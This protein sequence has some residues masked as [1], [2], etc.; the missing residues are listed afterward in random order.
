[1]QWRFGWGQKA[2]IKRWMKRVNFG[3]DPFHVEALCVFGRQSEGQMKR[4]RERSSKVKPPHPAS[5]YLGQEL[6]IK[7]RKTDAQLAQRNNRH[8]RRCEGFD[9]TGRPDQRLSRLLWPAWSRSHLKLPPWPAVNLLFACADA[10]SFWHG[11]VN[12]EMPT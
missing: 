11:C 10:F 3:K 9:W 7:V 6:W 4:G 1:M 12:S 2:K 5:L 8:R